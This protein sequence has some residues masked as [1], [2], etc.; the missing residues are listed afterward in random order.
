MV[1]PDEPY[2]L[3]VVESFKPSQFNLL[4][5]KYDAATPPVLNADRL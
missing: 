1:R 3:V 2:R 5:E 4:Q